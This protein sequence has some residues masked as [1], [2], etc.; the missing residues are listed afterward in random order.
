MVDSLDTMWI[1]GLH[2]EF[3][4]SMHAVANLT[5]ALPK[6]EYAPFFETVIRYLGGLL[7]AYAVSKEPLFLSRAEEL[8][9][10]LLP[11]FNTTSGLPRYAVNTVSGSTSFGWTGGAVLFAEAATCQ[12]EYKYLAHLTGRTEFYDKVESIMGKMYEADV[13]NGLFAERWNP[14]RA[15]PNDKHYSV[16]AAADSGYEYFLKQYLLS[17]KT[18][19]KARDQY[20]KSANGI[21]N[22]LVYISP[23]RKLLYVTDT[24]NGNPTHTLE[25]LSCFLPGLLALGVHTLGDSLTSREKQL[26]KWAAEG[27]AHTCWTTYADTQSGLGPDGVRFTAESS[28]WVPYLEKWEKEGG[29]GGIPPGL[30]EPPPKAP[31][32]DYFMSS[33][34]YL[35]RPET[36]ETFFVMYKTSGDVKWR[37]RGWAV[38]EALEK[39]AKNEHGFASVSNVDSIP[40][41]LN[42]DMPSFFLAE[43]L[44]YLYL[45]F[46]EKDL[47]PLDEWVF[48]TEA[49]PLPIFQ[50][51]DWEKKEYH[52]Q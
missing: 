44:K 21:I 33:H 42:D 34:V 40:T 36:V 51:K 6:F 24:I 39:H 18:E 3:N 52:I 46:A 13:P 22:N 9:Q 14:D 1:M 37:E 4:A 17:G 23:T 28:L 10:K 50:W 16:G 41:Y 38:F 32:R 26:H 19:V 31:T 27:L 25:H 47:I 7:S 49:H 12:M 30:T 29:S 45:L 2:E 11:V 5:F 8:G 20:I 43:T 48:N 35:L 15:T